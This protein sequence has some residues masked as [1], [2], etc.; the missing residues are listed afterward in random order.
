MQKVPAIGVRQINS[1]NQLPTTTN[2]T[3]TLLQLRGACSTFL[4]SSNGFHGLELSTSIRP[5]DPTSYAA[6][7]GLATCFSGCR[8]RAQH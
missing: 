7:W 3:N 6:A 1:N 5:D 4:V 8:S 2:E